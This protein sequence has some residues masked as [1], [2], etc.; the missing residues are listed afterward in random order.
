MNAI[1]YREEYY[2]KSKFLNF[3]H[4]VI[5]KR[6]EDYLNRIRLNKFVVILYG[7]FLFAIS[8]L[9]IQRRILNGEMGI[10]WLFFNGVLIFSLTLL[11]IRI[12]L[13]FFYDKIEHMNSTKRMYYYYFKQCINVTFIIA[14][15][16][17]I[18]LNLV[19]KQEAECSMPSPTIYDAPFCNQSLLNE[20]PMDVFLWMIIL[21]VLYQILLP[22]KYIYTVIVQLLQ[23]IAV[24]CAAYN[25]MKLP[26]AWP[27]TLISVGMYFGVVLIQYLMQND[28]LNNFVLKDTVQSVENNKECFKR[29]TQSKLFGS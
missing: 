20:M 23:L 11:V 16:I 13:E 17:T 9:L 26:T 21:L 14:H 28:M 2:R 8:P 22:V 18:G 15:S 5:R 19:L 27:L 4:P 1:R 29:D 24:M 7:A 10:G 25:T 6:Y 12:I 3:C